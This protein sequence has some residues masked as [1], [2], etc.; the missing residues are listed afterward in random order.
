MLLH[1]YRSMSIR[2][3]LSYL[4]PRQTHLQHL[5]PSRCNLSILCK[6]Y[7]CSGFFFLFLLRNSPSPS[8]SSPGPGRCQPRPKSPSVQ[9]RHCSAPQTARA[10]RLM[11]QTRERWRGNGGRRPE[12]LGRQSRATWCNES[13]R[14]PSSPPSATKAWDVSRSWHSCRTWIVCKWQSHITN[15]I[16]HHCNHPPQVAISTLE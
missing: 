7:V 13:G 10:P 14:S 6:K 2:Q 12:I 3:N 9:S 8:P 16:C 4:M 15:T 1:S 5:Q 11:S